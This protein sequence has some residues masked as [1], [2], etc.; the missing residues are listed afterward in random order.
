MRGSVKRE[1]S[2]RFQKKRKKKGRDL[3]LSQRE[4]KEGQ[5]EERDKY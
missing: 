5:R 1:I 3:R 2:I 4:T